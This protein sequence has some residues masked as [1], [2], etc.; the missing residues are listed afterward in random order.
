MGGAGAAGIIGGAAKAG[1]GR[2][3]TI[4]GCGDNG[5]SAIFGETGAGRPVPGSVLNR[6][7]SDSSMSR[8]RVS[9]SILVRAPTA[10]ATSQRAS[11]IGD[12]TTSKPTS[13]VPSIAFRL[14]TYIRLRRDRLIEKMSFIINGIN[15]SNHGALFLSAGA[16]GSPQST[17]HGPWRRTFLFFPRFSAL[18][19]TYPCGILPP[20]FISAAL[21]VILNWRRPG[22]PGWAGRSGQ[23]VVVSWAR[24]Y[25]ID[26]HIVKG[27]K[28]AGAWGSVPLG[29]QPKIRRFFACPSP[30]RPRCSQALV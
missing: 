11:T 19:R 27:K 3:S 1:S 26:T 18:F 30:P 25:I 14:L 5:A 4:R 12:P 2:L 6:W 10:R 29:V 13:I 17:V 24:L 16:A 22:G 20:L 28:R 15:A 23:S 8:R 21:P 7:S 9:S